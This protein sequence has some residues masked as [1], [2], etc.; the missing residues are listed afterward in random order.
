MSPHRW[1]SRV[2]CLFGCLIFALL[3]CETNDENGTRGRVEICRVPP[4]DPDN[5][6]TLLIDESTVDEYL[7]NNPNDRLG[8]C[9]PPCPCDDG[10]PCTSDACDADGECVFAMKDCEDG[11]ICTRNA[12]DQSTGEC[13][14]VADMEGVSCDDGVLCTSGDTCANGECLGEPIDGCCRNDDD[15]ETDGTLCTVDTCDMQTGNC[16]Q[17]DFVCSGDAC[18]P[19]FCVDTPD[20]PT[21]EATPVVCEDPDPCIAGTC[22]VTLS[23]DAEC[24]FN[25]VPGCRNCEFTWVET[26]AC[27]EDAVRSETLSIDQVPLGGGTACPGEDGDT[28]TTNCCVC[29]DKSVPLECGP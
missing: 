20:G 12:C 26:D 10:D 4:D 7:R 3:G 28:R 22:R 8:P 21:C 2:A 1:P 23:G 19:E 27:G 18:T 24:V 14:S 29:R 25:S 16:S 15:C 5:P 6:Q 17:E 9:D 13:T 11:N